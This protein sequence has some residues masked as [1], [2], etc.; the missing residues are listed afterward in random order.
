[1]Y[2]HEHTRMYIVTPWPPHHAPATS[3]KLPDTGHQAAPTADRRR[4]T[5][6]NPR[7][8][9]DLPA[10]KPSTQQQLQQPVAS[11]RQLTPSRTQAAANSQQPA[12]ST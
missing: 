3:H 7:P 2:M 10:P 12:L 9:T 5:I 6:D 11:S 8:T 4:P 1:M